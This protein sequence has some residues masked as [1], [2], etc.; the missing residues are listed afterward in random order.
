MDVDSLAWQL[1][2]AGTEDLKA[3]IDSGSVSAADVAS[4]AANPSFSGIRESDGTDS[5]T[6]WQKAGCH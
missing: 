3:I 2:K 1:A 6:G 4:L 5:G